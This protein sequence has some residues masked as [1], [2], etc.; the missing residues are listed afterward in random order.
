MS[1]HSHALLEDRRDELGYPIYIYCNGG[2]GWLCNYFLTKNDNKSFFR[3]SVTHA[4]LDELQTLL[5]TR[6]L[7]SRYGGGKYCNHEIT[8]RVIAV[9]QSFIN[10]C[11]HELNRVETVLFMATWSE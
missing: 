3:V 11:R 6:E 7:F 5:D 2:W 1:I 4:H 9:H 10:D 8:D